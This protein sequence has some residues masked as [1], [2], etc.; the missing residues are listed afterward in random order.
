MPHMSSSGMS[1]RQA[2]TAFQ[3][4]MVTFIVVASDRALVV[5]AIPRQL[6]CVLI[7]EGA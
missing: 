6:P 3:D 7:V 2:A 4:L 5:L 1:H